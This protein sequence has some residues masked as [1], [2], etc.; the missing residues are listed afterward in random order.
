VSICNENMGKVNYCSGNVTC[1]LLLAHYS[2]C[3]QKALQAE[4]ID[5]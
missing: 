1:D 3:F 2:R 5:R 4:I